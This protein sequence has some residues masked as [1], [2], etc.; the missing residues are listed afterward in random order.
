MDNTSRLVLKTSTK[1][2]EINPC[3]SGDQRNTERIQPVWF[4]RAT[5]YRQNTTCLALKINTTWRIHE[6]EHLSPDQENTKK[7]KRGCFVVKTER[8]SCTRNTACIF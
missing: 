6:R 3:G 4:W 7:L 8:I 5:L 2:R 1:R